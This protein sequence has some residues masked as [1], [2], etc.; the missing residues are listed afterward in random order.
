MTVFFVVNNDYQGIDARE[1]MVC[2]AAKGRDS[3]IIGVPHRLREINVDFKVNAIFR[4]YRRW[5]SPFTSLGLLLQLRWIRRH[6]KAGDSLI[7]YSEYEPINAMLAF[8]MKGN[9]G[10]VYLMED[11]GFATYTR[12]MDRDVK[13]SSRYSDKLCAGVISALGFPNIFRWVVY[14]DRIQGRISERLIDSVLLYRK[15]ANQTRIDSRYIQYETSALTSDSSLV[16]NVLYLG[17]DLYNAYMSLEEYTSYLTS[18]F[19]YLSLQDWTITYKPHPRENIKIAKEI[20]IGL[21]FKVHFLESAKAIENIINEYQ[22]D[23]VL[24]HSS[25]ACLALN[26]KGISTGFMIGRDLTADGNDILCDF[27]KQ[28]IFFSQNHN[29]E[30][31]LLDPYMPVGDTLVQICH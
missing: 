11:G 14:G 13:P 28:L 21:D 23:L 15:V 8:L 22:F 6:F 30:L 10:A 26:L 29:E 27:M 19:G 25:S 12:L 4:G 20:A 31:Y 5:L 16:S 7:V 24:S 17:Q 1:H 18:I 2:L 3:K 9:G